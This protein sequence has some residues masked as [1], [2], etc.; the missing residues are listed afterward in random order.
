MTHVL[1][2]PAI[3]RGRSDQLKLRCGYDTMSRTEATHWGEGTQDE[4]CVT[5]LFV[6][7]P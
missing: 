7:L 6:K 2:R 3:H 4:M 5:G 1:L